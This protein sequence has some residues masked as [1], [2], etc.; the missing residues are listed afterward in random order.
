MFLVADISASDY[1][2]VVRVTPENFI[3]TCRFKDSR[4]ALYTCSRCHVPED[5]LHL[6]SLFRRFFVQILART[7][8]SCE[9][10]VWFIWALPDILKSTIWLL[11]YDLFII[12]LNW[13]RVTIKVS[14]M[15]WV[16]ARDFQHFAFCGI[17]FQH[18]G[19]YKPAQS[20]WHQWRLTC[21]Y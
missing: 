21:V 16:T 7:A 11:S 9:R 6:P 12:T 5:W 13:C 3:L 18:L 17:P 10:C 1:S 20:T 14:W 2:Y 15:V 8:S 4:E 19:L